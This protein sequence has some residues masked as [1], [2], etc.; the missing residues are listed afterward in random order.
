MII[1]IPTNNAAHDKEIPKRS[2]NAAYCKYVYNAGFTPILIPMEANAEEIAATADGLLLAG[3]IDVDPIYYGDSNSASY[4]TDPEKDKAE[5]ELFHAFRSNN[6]P[7]FGICRGFQLIMRELL[8]SHNDSF[9][10]NKYFEYLENIGSH[11]QTSTLSVAR[12]FPSH[13]VRADLA[14][15]YGKKNAPVELMAVNSMHHQCVA[16]NHVHVAKMLEPELFN[17]KNFDY[18]EPSVLDIKNVDLLAWS[19]RGVSKP[20]KSNKK[21][22]LDNYWSIAEAVRINDWGGQIMGVQWHPEELN[23]I[24]LLKNFFDNEKENFIIGDA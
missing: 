15:L 21:P 2:Q 11:A 16:V 7:I 1:A 24:A 14:G 3:G 13:Q 22:D 10:Y 6:K 4:G 18:D 17:S 9:T 12:R 5:R 8:Y 19:L 20:I 23:D